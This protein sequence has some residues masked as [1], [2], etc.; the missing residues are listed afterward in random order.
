MMFVGPFGGF[1]DLIRIAGRGQNLG[2]QRVG[3][4]RNPRHQPV[5]LSRGQHGLRKR[6]AAEARQ[7]CKRQRALEN[8]PGDQ[9]LIHLRFS[10]LI[11]QDPSPESDS[12]RVLLCYCT[13][14]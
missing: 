4:K 11:Q 1:G 6:H 5:E 9:S 14:P 12:E 13:L 10:S 3:I 7:Q 8:P 2:E